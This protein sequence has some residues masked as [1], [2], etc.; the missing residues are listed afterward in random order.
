MA[1]VANA[2]TDSGIKS[3]FAMGY[4]C[5]VL[6]DQTDGGILNNSVCILEEPKH[7]N[8]YRAPGEGWTKVFNY[9]VGIVHTNYVEYAGLQF[10]G[11]WTVSDYVCMVQFIHK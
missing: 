10:H 11:L 9:V 7:L 3:I 1:D 8:W 5:A 6:C 4:I 2:D